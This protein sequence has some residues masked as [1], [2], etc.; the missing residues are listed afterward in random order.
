MPASKYF[1]GV[2]GGPDYSDGDASHRPN[3]P[4]YNRANQDNYLQKIGTKWMEEEIDKFLYGHPSHK[5]FNSP[6]HFYPHF[7]YLMNHGNGEACVC[8]LCSG[9]RIT[10]TARMSA[11]SA[12]KPSRG[13]PS[14]QKGPVDEEGTPDVFSSLF[15]L[16]KSEGQLSRKIE[17]RSSMDWRAEKPLVD[18]FA[19]SIPK[20]H[21]FIP[22]HGEIVLYLRP[23]VQP[24]LQPRQDPNTH[25]FTIYDALKRTDTGHAQ[26]LAGIVTQVPS[27]T[28]PLSLSNLASSTS[29]TDSDTSS[30]SLTG[31]RI[32]PLPSPNS[33][34]KN[35]S[36]QHTYTPFHLIRPFGFWRSCLHGIPEAEWHVSIH[37]ALALSATV[38]LTDRH[39]FKGR[40][41]DAEIYSRGIFVGA[42]AYW[43]GDV[44][45][46]LP[47]STSTSRPSTT[48]STVNEKKH[49]DLQIMHIQ[50]IITTFHSLHRSYSSPSPDSSTHISIRLRGAVYTTDPSLC[51]FAPASKPHTLPPPMD[52]YP[53]GTLFP[54][55]H[56][57]VYSTPFSG[58]LSRLYPSEALRLWFPFLPASTM[59]EYLS[60]G[61]TDVIQG[62]HIAASTDSRLTGEKKWYWADCRADA[63]DL[64]TVQGMEVGKRGEESREVGVG[65]RVLGVLDGIGG[66]GGVEGVKSVGLGRMVEKWGYR[67]T[68]SEGLSRGRGL[69]DDEDDDEEEE[70]DGGEGGRKRM[71][72]EVKMPIVG[73]R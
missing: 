48:T 45:R 47:S 36:K 53:A 7:K 18:A 58:V 70:E 19:A 49:N 63:L 8:E 40:W 51:A 50:S 12:S 37:N 29:Q 69:D 61:R 31:F 43:V 4:N 26:W 14:L 73:R 64:G 72:V 24:H 71:R 57:N 10:S 66:G 9:S 1:G 2:I 68:E 6:Y 17:E 20:Q 32:E 44:V 22:R 65:R 62:R 23:L 15:S 11:P 33:Q 55:S 28:T 16:L 13:R 56:R 67:G 59:Q 38:S 52:T 41:P 5:F 42:E 27:S 46:L 21:S 3:K 54:L 34:D 35:L 30:F 39:H 60:L 25:S